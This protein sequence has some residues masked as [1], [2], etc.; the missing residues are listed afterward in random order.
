MLPQP[1]LRSSCDGCGAAKVK[2]DRG[3]PACARCISLGQVCFYGISR[4]TGKPRRNKIFLSDP[5]GATPTPSKLAPT[6]GENIHQKRATS[7]E[8]QDGAAGDLSNRGIARSREPML[9]DPSLSLQANT[10]N[11][12]SNPLWP[13]L[14]RIDYMEFDDLL[15]T[16]GESESTFAPTTVEAESSAA[17]VTQ[18]EPNMSEYVGRTLIPL[19]GS[20]DHNCFQEAYDILGS[21]S[22]LRSE[23]GNSTLA[24][25]PSDSGSTTANSASNRVPLD[26]V[27]SVNRDARKGLGRILNC[28]C[29]KN[30]QLTILCSLI[31]SQ[32]FSCYQQAA[33]FNPNPS[34]GA[35]S[36]YG[37]EGTKG[38]PVQT[39]RT[40][41]VAPKMTIGN[42]S[43]DDLRVQNGLK[44]HLLLD[45]MRKVGRLIDLLAPQ[46]SDG[47]ASDYTA[48]GVHGL[49]ET[50]NAWL[51]SEYS[52]IINMIMAK[53]REFTT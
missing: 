50:L 19:G 20:K 43:I 48:G 39:S 44:N 29:A 46:D 31:I 51:H 10:N 18:P 52:R 34:F 25:S 4:K 24:S 13:I 16:Q 22:F 37:P 1:K 33:G 9:A 40:T 21:L 5:L 41:F 53:L 49:Y 2:C 12:Q 42:F 27:L 30:A 7:T 6:G 47:T 8:S 45:E 32:I 28:S 14:P 15:W 38:A 3:L 17:S 36:V 23:C 11:I 26:H 35:L